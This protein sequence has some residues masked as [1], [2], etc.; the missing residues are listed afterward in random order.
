MDAVVKAAQA[1]GHVLVDLHDDGL[2]AL[3]HRLQV[4][5]AGAEVEPAMLVHGCHLEHGHIQSLDAVAV[6]AGQLG[7][8]QGDVVGKALIDGLALDAAHVPGVPCEV[9]SGIGHVKNRR[10]VGQDAAPD[11]DVLQLPHPL[12]Q[13][14]VQ[15]IGGADA[16]A[17]IH[18]V[19]GL[20]GL[21][22]L[23]SG[24]QFLLILFPKAHVFVPPVRYGYVA[25]LV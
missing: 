15:R 20:D 19:T 14:H 18:P 1:H 12:G 9:L 17:V 23:V 21:H 8:A 3:A 24:G 10:P 16:P 25:S 11:V 2:G 13:S 4:G 5:A 6:V 7:V 22:C